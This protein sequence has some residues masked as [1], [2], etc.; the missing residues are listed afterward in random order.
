MNKRFTLGLVLFLLAGCGTPTK[1]SSSALLTPSSEGN[2]SSLT[3]SSSAETPSSVAEPTPSPSPVSSSSAAQPS[4][5]LPSSTPTQS[6][7]ATPTSSSRPTSSSSSSYGG[8]DGY[9]V[10]SYYS[11]VSG[12][13][14]SLFDSLHTRLNKG[15]TTLG[16][17]GLLDVYPYSDVNED[18]TIHDYYSKTTHYH[19]GDANKNYSAEGDSFNREHSIPKSWWGGSKANQG[20]DVYIVVPTDGYVNNRRSNYPF[21]LTN[22]ETYKS[23]GDYCKLGPSLI[24]S[25]NSTDVFEPGDDKKGDFARIHFYALTKWDN[26]WNWTQGN[27]GSTFS[28]SLNTNMGLTDYALNLFLQWHSQ[29][30]VDDYERNKND[31]AVQYQHNRNPYVDHP[32]WVNSIWGGNY[33]QPSPTSITLRASSDLIYVGDTMTVNASVAPAGAN[34]QVTF[35]S[36]NPSVASVNDDGL[37]TGLSTGIATIQAVSQVDSSVTATIEIE[38]RTRANVDMESITCK[39]LTV[40]EG[41]ASRL[42]IETYP[43]NAYPRPSYTFASGNDSIATVDENGIVTGVSEGETEITIVATQG[44]IVYEKRVAVTV[45][46]SLGNVF[47]KATSP[48]TDGNYLIVYEAG[49]KVLNANEVK[50][51]KNNNAQ[52]NVAINN[53]VIEGDY[54]ALCFTITHV[55]QGYAI[56]TPSGKYVCASGKG[57]FDLSDH[58]EYCD[59]QMTSD[60][61]KIISDNYILMYNTDASYFRFYGSSSSVGGI[62]TLYRAE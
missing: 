61:A 29:D 54:G 12:S 19:M 30:P 58:D 43:F 52:T 13:G 7:S 28:G 9:D 31:V 2:S 10:N 47:R 60:G 20:C 51:N 50:D 45:L 5:T 59:I 8:G 56:R 38:V 62:A 18:G 23:H 21:G 34:G 25:Y 44:E 6:S 39:A 48:I 15:F 1:T 42:E 57:S 14:R 33:V 16:Y 35:T 26:A 41:K 22:G 17:D 55:S 24:S 36:L 11:S 40:Y 3:A 32:E 49:E 53:G 46:A 4:S 37:V 27:G